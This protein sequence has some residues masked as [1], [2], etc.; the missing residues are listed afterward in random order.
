MLGAAGEESSTA[1]WGPLASH[2]SF[3]SVWFRNAVRAA[4]GLALAV[5]IVE[6]TDVE[7]GFWVVL[8]TLSV[9]RSN[10]LGT[11]STALRAVGGTAV[12]VVVGSVIMIGVA[13][14]SVLL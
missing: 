11:G 5:A 6:I 8:D 1:Y 4:V 14:H 10:A 3:R 9:L 7:H 12:G 13:G 2:L